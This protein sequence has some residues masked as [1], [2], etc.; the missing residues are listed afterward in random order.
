MQA[1]L[2]LDVVIIHLAIAYDAD[3]GGS[4]LLLTLRIEQP[5]SLFQILFKL[6]K[7]LRG[8]PSDGTR[9]AQI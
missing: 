9:A 4:E 2:H 8:A 1:S 3:I 6:R 5:A 7:V